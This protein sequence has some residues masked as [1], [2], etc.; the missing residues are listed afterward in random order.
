LTW[1]RLVARFAYWAENPP[2]AVALRMALQGF[3]VWKPK[4]KADAGAT[5]EKL[6]AL[7]PGGKL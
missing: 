2:V 7:F 4:V 6:Q 5:L 3:G 1:P